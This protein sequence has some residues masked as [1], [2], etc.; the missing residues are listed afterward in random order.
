MIKRIKKKINKIKSKQPL[1]SLLRSL[2]NLIQQDKEIKLIKEVI[3]KR[4]KI[5]SRQ[6]RARSNQKNLIRLIILH[7]PKLRK[8][9]KLKSKTKME[10]KRLISHYLTQIVILLKNLCKKDLRLEDL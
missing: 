8:M 4:V 10:K 2:Q 6:T 7:Q 3:A 9:L 1:K 5:V